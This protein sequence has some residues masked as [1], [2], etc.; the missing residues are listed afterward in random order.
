[1]A[2]DNLLLEDIDTSKA[3]EIELNERINQLDGAIA[4]TFVYNFTDDADYILNTND[5]EEYLNMVMEIT[6]TDTEL[7]TG[8]N[9]ILPD[10]VSKIWWIK[11]STAETI[12]FVNAVSGSAGVAVATTADALIRYD[13]AD[14]YGVTL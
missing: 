6:D 10:G 13:G 3:P 1:M 2:T 5:E 14:A 8:R 7:S 11:N 12:T 9:I 4:G